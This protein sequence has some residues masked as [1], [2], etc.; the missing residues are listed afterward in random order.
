MVKHQ[1]PSGR[2]ASHLQRIPEEFFAK[3]NELND[4]LARRPKVGGSR[5]I[6]PSSMGGRLAEAFGSRFNRHPFMPTEKQLNIA[7]GK[8]MMHQAPV[9]VATIKKALEH[10]LV[11]DSFEAADDLFS[12]IRMVIVLSPAARNEP[13]SDETC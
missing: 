6:A 1:L 7:K 3:Y 2:D 13:T 4:E 11:E 5:G 8:V 9:K 12:T 10:A